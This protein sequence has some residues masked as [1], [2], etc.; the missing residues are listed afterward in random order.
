MTDKQ[1]VPLQDTIW[2]RDD[3]D[4]GIEMT[5]FH[6]PKAVTYSRIPRITREALETSLGIGASSGRKFELREIIAALKRLGIEVA[7]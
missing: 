3:G 7:T 6:D 5:S 4:G 1:A 2:M